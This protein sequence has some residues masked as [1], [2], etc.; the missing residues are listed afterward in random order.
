MTCSH[1]QDAGLLLDN[2]EPAVFVDNA[3]IVAL[4]DLLVTLGLAES[5]LHTGRQQKVKLGHRL[6]IHTYTLTLK[7]LLDFGTCLVNVAQQELQQRLFFLDL[8]MVVFS[9]GICVVSHNWLQNY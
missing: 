1:G 6:P 9:L 5:H 8:I 7:G 2:D 4:E 3:Q